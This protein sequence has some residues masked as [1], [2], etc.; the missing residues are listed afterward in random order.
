[1]EVGQSV[2]AVRHGLAVQDNL[3]HPQRPQGLSDCQELLRPVAAVAAP[4]THLIPALTGD[5][6]VAV[7]FDFMQPLRPARRPL[8]ESGLTRLDKTRRTTPLAGKR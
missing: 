8:R 1:M 4:Q 6:P 3:L 2:L 5:D 7:E